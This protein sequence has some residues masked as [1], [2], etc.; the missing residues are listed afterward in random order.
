MHTVFVGNGILALTA[1]FRLAKRAASSDRITIIGK[2]IRPGSATL[3]AAAMLNSFAEI[4]KDSLDSELDLY[5]FEMSHLATR[6][7]PKFE[8]EVIEAA[9]DSLPQGCAKCEGFPGGGCV[10]IGTYVVNN[11][12]ADDLDDE[13]FDAI[14]SALKEFDEPFEHVSPRDI[15]NYMPEQKHRA[16]RAVYIHNEGWFNPRLMIEK[17]DAVLKKY[18]QVT[19]IDGSVEKLVKTGAT[20]EAVVIENGQVIGGD[21]FVLATGATVTD[22][23]AKSN[24]GIEVQRIFYGVGV[25]V[26]IK[27]TD[28]PHKKCIRTPNRGLACGLYSVPY[29][30]D[31]NLPNDHVLIG[32]SNFMS[33]VPYNYGRL[34]SVESLMRGAMEQINSNFY[35]AD[36]VRVN[37]GWRPTSQDTYPLLGKTS[38]SNLIIATGTKRDGFHLSPLISEKIVALLYDEPVEKQFAWFDPERKPIRTMSREVAISKAVRHQMSAAYQHDFTPSKSRMP[39]QLK[40]MYR[41]GLER[42]HDQVGAHD[43]GIPPEML[44]MYRYGHAVP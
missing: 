28:Y 13:N 14:V 35:R 5:R 22:I 20:I 33:P 18:P 1:A 21:K 42:L 40:Q 32:A 39:D 12:A 19:F 24:L 2:P 6:M 25:S 30:T 3:A 27:S 37:V 29:F 41:D 36:L 11:T 8:K 44:D 16:T 4:E 17:L 7:W 9:G 34:T 26:E 31:P 15:P 23:L 10:D 38:I 43:W